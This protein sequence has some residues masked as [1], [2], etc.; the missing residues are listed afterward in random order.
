MFVGN[1]LII[2]HIKEWLFG[3]I[4]LGVTLMALFPRP[5]DHCLFLDSSIPFAETMETS[6]KEIIDTDMS[7]RAILL[8]DPSLVL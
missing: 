2:K 1:F 7:G 4:V 3:N 6:P 8:S 5:V